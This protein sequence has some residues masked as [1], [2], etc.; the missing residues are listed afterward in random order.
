MFAEVLAGI[1]LVKSAVDR[2]QSA[3]SA[4][5]GRLRDCRLYGQA[6]PGTNNR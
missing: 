1:A 4:R 6:F 5:P 3:I 2:H